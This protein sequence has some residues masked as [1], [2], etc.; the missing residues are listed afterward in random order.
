[1]IRDAGTLLE[2]YKEIQG[3]VSHGRSVLV[4]PELVGSSL[5]VLLEHLIT[6]RAPLIVLGPRSAVG[7][8][9]VVCHPLSILA[10][11]RRVQER[12]GHEVQRTSTLRL[13]EGDAK[14]IRDL[15]KQCGITPF[16]NNVYESPLWTH[17]VIWENRSVIA[18]A[19]LQFLPIDW[20]AQCRRVS[21]LCG[22]AVSPERQGVGLGRRIVDKT[23]WVAN[24]D[25]FAF[26]EKDSSTQFFRRIGWVPMGQAWYIPAVE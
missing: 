25:V 20:T 26:T 7:I 14:R 18:A 6:E 21:L 24:T 8:S 10:I 1:M 11:R 5:K 16:P 4:W 9:N 2:G 13:K 12:S 23:T 15:H 19:S 17:Q 3:I 22:V